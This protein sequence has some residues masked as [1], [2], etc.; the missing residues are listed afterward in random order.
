MKAQ[1]QAKSR[2][3]GR[4]WAIFGRLDEKRVLGASSGSWLE[5]L[6]VAYQ[7]GEIGM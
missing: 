5:M 3:R 1:I 2:N 7:R 4:D 6:L